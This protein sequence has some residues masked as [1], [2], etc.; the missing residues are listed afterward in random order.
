MKKRG[1]NLYMLESIWQIFMLFLLG[2]GVYVGVLL[3][4]ALKK[5]LKSSESKMDEKRDNKD[6]HS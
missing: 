6:K 5:Y 2:L 4:R 1:D 3:V